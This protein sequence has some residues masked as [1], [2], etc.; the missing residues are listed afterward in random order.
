MQAFFNSRVAVSDGEPAPDFTLLDTEG[1][2]VG[3]ADYAGRPVVINF[4]G[5]WCGPCI[6]E[7]PGLNSSAR[8]HP[9]VVFLGIAIPGDSPQNLRSL[10]RAK[11]RL[12][13]PF[14]VLDADAL[15]QQAY[16]VRVLPTTFLV[17]E[18]GRVSRHQV[19]TI[20][21]SRLASWLR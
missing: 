5:T 8:S 11:K 17:D 4:W 15:V 2:E 13:I 14:Q 21:E 3:L 6:Q 16:G 10:A 20:S 19:G 18:Q 1:N 9:E 7:M 12:D